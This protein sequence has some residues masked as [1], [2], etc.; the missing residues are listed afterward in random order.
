MGQTV[1]SFA[2][3]FWELSPEQQDLF[4]EQLLW[5][6][7][8]AQSSFKAP[9]VRACVRACVA[10]RLERDS[11]GALARGQLWTHIA[12]T[13]ASLVP[14]TT[15]HHHQQ[16]HGKR[17]AGLFLRA[18]RAVPVSCCVVRSFVQGAH[19][20]S[21]FGYGFKSPLRNFSSTPRRQRPIKV[22]WLRRCVVVLLVD[23]VVVGRL[24]RCL[25]GSALFRLIFR[26]HLPNEFALV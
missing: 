26:Y 6:S 3:K 24:C 16:Q 19:D 15:S 25:L 4:H 10:R 8:A 22:G 17:L 5:H 2:R 13:R 9:K 1:L 11:L 18:C 20:S 23:R 7:K 12:L 14:R 21:A